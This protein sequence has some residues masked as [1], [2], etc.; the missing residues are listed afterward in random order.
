MKTEEK[1]CFNTLIDGEHILYDKKQYIN[2]YKAFDIYFMNS[3][4]QRSLPLHIKEA[5]KNKIL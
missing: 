4:D 3:E 5:C 1:S 2:V